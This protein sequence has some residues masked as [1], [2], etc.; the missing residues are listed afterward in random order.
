MLKKIPQEIFFSKKSPYYTK[1][2]EFRSERYKASEECLY[3]TMIE[4]KTN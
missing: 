2:N 4:S 3:I 1:P